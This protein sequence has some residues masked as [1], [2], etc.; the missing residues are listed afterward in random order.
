[1]NTD[2]SLLHNF[3]FESVVTMSGNSKVFPAVNALS[4][5]SSVIIRQFHMQVTQL[6]TGA[7]VGLASASGPWSNA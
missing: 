5:V 3:I 1:M 7:G 4:P 2:A 6:A